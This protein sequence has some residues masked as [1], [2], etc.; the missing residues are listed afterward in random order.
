MLNATFQALASAAMTLSGG[1]FAFA[2]YIL[3]DYV[4]GELDAF[5]YWQ[6]HHRTL[7]TLVDCEYLSG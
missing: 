4:F 5:R 2:V 6:I 3:Q 1:A 7:T